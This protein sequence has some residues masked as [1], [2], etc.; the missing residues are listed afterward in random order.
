MKALVETQTQ[1]ARHP[2]TETQMPPFR[3]AA[4]ASAQRRLPVSVGPQ[5][6]KQSLSYFAKF[7]HDVMF[8]MWQICGR[9][10]LIL[11][12]KDLNDRE[13]TV[14]VQWRISHW[15]LPE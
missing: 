6:S 14:V 8:A 11:S 5:R 2:R 9:T 12:E 15:L 4:R 13:N 3:A 10:E 1:A 7:L